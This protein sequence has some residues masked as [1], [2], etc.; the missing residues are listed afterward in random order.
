MNTRLIA[1]GICAFLTGSLAVVL[2]FTGLLA[3][4]LFSPLA[5]QDIFVWGS[6]LHPL[7]NSYFVWKADPVFQPLLDLLASRAPSYRLYFVIQ[8][9]LFSSGLCLLLTLI[10]SRAWPAV[11]LA[12]LTTISF[13][14]I[15]GTDLILF[16]GICWI[17]W[18]IALYRSIQ[19]GLIKGPMLLLFSLF[20][21]LRLMHAHQ[22]AIP[23]L[24]C[25]GTLAAITDRFGEQKFS[26]IKALCLILISLPVLI[27]MKSI[28]FPDII[29]Y[30]SYAFVTPDDGLPGNILPLVTA[31]PN[32]PFLDHTYINSFLA[33][34]CIALLALIFLNRGFLRGLGSERTLHVITLCSLLG[35][36]AGLLPAKF[37]AI[38]PLAVLERLLPH[39]LFVPIA[40]V[41]VFLIYAALLLATW[42]SYAHSIRSR[43]SV[44]TISLCCLM[45]TAVFHQFTNNIDSKLQAFDSINQLSTE[46]RR[47][48]ASPSYHVIM[49]YGLSS[50]SPETHEFV[51]AARFIDQIQTSHSP[52][53]AQL[54]LDKK[55]KSRWSPGKGMQTGDEWIEIF[56][57]EPLELNG[58]FLDTGDF[59]F[60]FPAAIRI[61][62]ANDCTNNSEIK[63][64]KVQELNP[65]PGRL[66]YTPKGYP[67]FGSQSE[68]AITFERTRAGC[69]RIEQTGV[70]PFDWSIAKLKLSREEDFIR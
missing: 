15:F 1:C 9:I 62:T 7:Y 18:A 38:L 26:F 55:S 54:M 16:Q 67:F 11:F 32:I 48:L 24:L 28:P 21:G 49:A 44:L 2:F 6:Y 37:S 70:R 39:M 45:A 12:V 42:G 35:V 53:L 69:L 65:W 61:S 4:S 25:F 47:H 50:L 20:F 59:K 5:D 34:Y 22:Y 23:A 3:E 56:F 13:W 52:D 40:P 27:G 30:P 10:E 64:S 60:D 58:V 14:I 43:F 36:G 66:N 17:P 8:S 19:S 41:W 63:W 57:K 51:A 68:V 31:A 33:F 29:D 46:Q